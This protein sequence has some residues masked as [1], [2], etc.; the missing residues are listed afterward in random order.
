MSD[1]AIISLV[2]GCT[3][4]FMTVFGSAVLLAYRLGTN[5]TRID[6]LEVS[7]ENERKEMLEKINLIFTKIDTL[8]SGY[9]HRCLQIESIASMVARQDNA[10][11]RLA[12]HTQRMDRIQQDQVAMRAE[13]VRMEAEIQKR[14][15]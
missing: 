4:I 15:Q 3:I 9:P 11:E 14:A 10:F 5:A 7:V 12:E 8:S 13:Q 6:K 2:I 1:S